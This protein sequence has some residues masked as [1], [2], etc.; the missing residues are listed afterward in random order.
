MVQNVENHADIVGTLLSISDAPSHPGFVS[1]KVK[2][3]SAAAVAGFPNLLER[4]V[5]EHVEVLAPP[6]LRAHLTT[7]ARRTA[8]LYR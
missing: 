2:V 3:E 4:N 1:L 5:G 8:R 7:L 6:E